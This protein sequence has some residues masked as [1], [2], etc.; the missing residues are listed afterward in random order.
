MVY[1]LASREEEDKA[2]NIALDIANEIAKKWT[3]RD[4]R[5]LVSISK[6]I[7]GLH[8]TI[9]ALKE[10]GFKK[11]ISQIPDE[12]LEI[13]IEKLISRLEGI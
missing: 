10:K 12:H 7:S 5:G 2:I 4:I 3:R 6:T 13:A 9:K 1:K 11:Q 8:A